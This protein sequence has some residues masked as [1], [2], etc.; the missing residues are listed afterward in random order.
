MKNISTDELLEKLK[1]LKEEFMHSSC[2]V[3]GSVIETVRKQSKKEKPFYYLS[4]SI[5]GKTKTT[6]IS[7]DSL[8]AF[9]LAT[10]R[11]NRIKEIVGKINQINIQLVKRGDYCVSQ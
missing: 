1:E 9:K 11:G 5:G 10:S 3:A 2:W 8:E 6:Y 4:Q 7:A